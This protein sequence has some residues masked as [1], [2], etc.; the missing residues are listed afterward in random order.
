MLLLATP[1]LRV[2]SW[3]FSDDLLGRCA[4]LRDSFG[5]GRSDFADLA[6]GGADA[7]DGIDGISGRVLH[8]DDLCG[9]LVGCLAGLGGQILHLAGDDCKSL[10]RL[11]GTG[12]FDRRIQ[13]EQVGLTGDVLDQ[14]DDITDPAPCFDEAPDQSVGPLRL[15]DRGSSDLRGLRDP[16]ADLLNRRGQLLGRR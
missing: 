11:T 9:D 16:M 6:D 13:R 3:T 7:L 14:L 2:T 12:R 8:R 1:L 4:L 5:D 15:L 10:A